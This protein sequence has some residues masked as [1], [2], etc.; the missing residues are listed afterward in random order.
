[1]S[2]DTLQPQPQ[3]TSHGEHSSRVTDKDVRQ[4]L[5]EAVKQLKIMNLHL[6]IMSEE[7]I[8]KEDIE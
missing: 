6:A 4:L 1:M 5:V 3:D 7:I 2:L 8:S